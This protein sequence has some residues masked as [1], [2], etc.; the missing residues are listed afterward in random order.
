MD[1]KKESVDGVQ[2]FNDLCCLEHKMD[3]GRN[4][5]ASGTIKSIAV[6]LEEQLQETRDVIYS[7]EMYP[8][9]IPNNR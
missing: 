5:S 4:A 7:T 1:E 3:V 9:L 2:W 8:I 6:R